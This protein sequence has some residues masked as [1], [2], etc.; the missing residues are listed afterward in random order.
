[1]SE[2][3][4]GLAPELARGGEKISAKILRK[5]R[6]KKVSAKISRKNIGD[7]DVRNRAL[8]PLS[9]KAGLSRQRGVRETLSKKQ[10]IVNFKSG[11]GTS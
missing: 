5:T 11:S 3:L 8:P 7:C 2:H 10:V 1:M 4:S 6:A 9:R